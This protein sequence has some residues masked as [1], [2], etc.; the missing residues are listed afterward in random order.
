MMS[1]WPGP[2]ANRP[3]VWTTG[4]FLS[5]NRIV[6]ALVGTAERTAEMSYP[7]LRLS[8]FNGTTPEQ[9]YSD[10][11]GAFLGG[12]GRNNDGPADR[13][14]T[15]R[16]GEAFSDA[17]SLTNDACGQSEIGQ[18]SSDQRNDTYILPRHHLGVCHTSR[19][20]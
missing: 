17:L 16:R 15:L 19:T 6:G 13:L 12:Y 1:C 4:R 3:V 11:V 20:R 18:R 10:S 8:Q 7:N 5:A 14:S 2:M 9:R